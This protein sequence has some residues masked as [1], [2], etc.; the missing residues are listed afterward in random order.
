MDLWDFIW[1]FFWTFAFI[2]Y[3]SVLFAIIGDL[4]RDHELNGW[5]K[6]VWIFFLIFL[7]FITALVYLIARG[8]RMAKR[9]ARRAASMQAQTDQYIRQTAGTQS[10][11]DEIAKAKALLDAGTITPQ[12]Y[13]ALKAKALG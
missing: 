12:E 9:S 1:F 4:F 6:A 5:L 2:A 8:D 10:P 11:T 7:P 3:L 13:E